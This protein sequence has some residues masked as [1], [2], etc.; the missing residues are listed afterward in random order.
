MSGANNAPDAD[1]LATSLEGT[2]LQ[3][4]YTSIDKTN[5][6]GLN[7]TVPEDAQA[8]IKPWDERNDT[9][10]SAQSNVDDQI[11][12][13]VPFTQ[14]VRVRSV[15]LKLGRGEETPRHLRL[16]ANHNTIVDFAEAEEI[17]PQLD[18]TLQEGEVGVT[19]YPLRAATFA[20]VFSLSLYF[21]NAIGSDV[22]RIFYIGFRGDNRGQRKEGTNKLE[23]PAANAP[24][25]KIIDR[26]TEKAGAQQT[27]AR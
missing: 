6:H 16:Y 10:V 14:N 25:A 21:N 13:H 24:D 4:L 9:S 1:T 26:V 5:V 20:N 17:T 2:D 18:I 22:A 12:I 15:L 19:E 27:T 11:I 8:V 7:L 23:I 3:N